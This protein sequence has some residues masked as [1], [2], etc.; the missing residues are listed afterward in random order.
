MHC[1]VHNLILLFNNVLLNNLMSLI[2]HE[3][4]NPLNYIIG[5]YISLNLFKAIIFKQ[6]LHTKQLESSRFS[7]T[8]LVV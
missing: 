1:C 3:I 8:Y 7:N 4:S 2:T 6:I 5:H